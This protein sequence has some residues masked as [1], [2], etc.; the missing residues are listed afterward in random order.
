MAHFNFYKC[1][2]YQRQIAL[3]RLCVQ[4]TGR[5]TFIFPLFSTG[6][7]DVVNNL[8]SMAARFL[9]QPIEESGHLFFSQLLER[10]KPLK[11]QNKVCIPWITFPCAERHAILLFFISL[12]RISLGPTDLQIDFH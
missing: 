8:G 5:V 3:K 12:F 4:Q 1:P 11:E 9:F 10:G 7:Y 6:I 2:K